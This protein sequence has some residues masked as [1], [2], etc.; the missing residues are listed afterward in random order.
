MKFSIITVNYNNCSGLRHTIESVLSQSC[1]DYEFIII[2]A[3][4]TDGSKELLEEYDSQIDY[5]VSE[6]DK[7]IYNGM[8]KGILK[9]QGDYIN[10]MNS[11]DIFFNSRTLEKVSFVMDGS[12]I[13]VGCD[14]NIDPITGESATT[15]LPI[16]VSFATFFM[17]T[18]PHQSS[19]IKRTL[20][21][22]SP[23][24]EN[25]EIV[26]DWK[27]FLEKVCF[28][29]CSTQLINI[30]ISQREQGGIS[31]LQVKK[32]QQ[33]RNSFLFTILP[34]GIKKDYDSLSKLDYNTLYKLLNLCDTPNS[35]K[36]LTWTIKLLYRIFIHRKQKK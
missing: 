15:I 25:Y 16:R 35:K 6:P 27:F 3:G 21:N 8:N 13:I 28:D 17:Q 36:I 12:D 23:Y 19:F 4:S 24:D 30:A 10:F 32:A 7:G 1:K 29:G 18:F 20:F 33:E 14:Y 22:F 31:N 26:A 34:I 9:A 11:G 5:W 2:D